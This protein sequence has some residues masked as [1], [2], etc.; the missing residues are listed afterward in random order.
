MNVSFSGCGFLG[1]Y[2]MG[3]VSCLKTFAPKLFLNKVSGTSAGA[4]AAVTAL[5]V[6]TEVDVRIGEMASDILGV[7]IEAR[8]S[9]L[10]PFSPSFDPNK[11]IYESLHKILPDDVHLKVNGRLHVSVTSVYDGTN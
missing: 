11:F 8:K 10:G 1:L 9:L 4:I 2:H 6:M 5:T 7:C 3:V